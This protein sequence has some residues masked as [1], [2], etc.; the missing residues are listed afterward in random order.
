[1]PPLAPRKLER[2]AVR[3]GIEQVLLARI[4]AKRLSAGSFVR[5]GFRKLGAGKAVAVGEDL[6]HRPFL[7]VVEPWNV[8]SVNDQEPAL[9]LA[10]WDAEIQYLKDCPI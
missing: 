2:S 5:F 9:A 3:I 4:G 10:L 8:S 6:K 1:M 7:S